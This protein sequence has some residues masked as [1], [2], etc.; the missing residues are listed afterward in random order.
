MLPPFEAPSG[1]RVVYTDVDGTMLGRAGA[2]VRDPSGALTLE[3]AEALTQTLDAGID[4]VPCSGRAL[5][6]LVGDARILGLASVIGEMGSVIAYEHG[7]EVVRNLG[8]YP[9]GDVL[10]VVY[11]KECGAVGL[12]LERYRLEHHTPWSAWREYTHLFRGLVE[13]DEA[14]QALALAGFG[15]CEIQDNGRLHGAYVGLPAGSA[16]AYHLVPRGT[17]KASAVLLDRTRRGLMPEECVAIGDAMADLGVARQ[18]A[19]LVLVRDALER[20]EAL[21][22][23]ATAAPN[24]FSTERPGNLGW[25]EV[26]SALARAR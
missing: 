15:W 26:V 23:A 5:R 9:G 20:D 8:E 7:A 21:A 14:N 22:A 10:P 13:V 3:P 24:A 2:F 25:A 11:M 17:S 18:V 19:A 12:L 4:V 1:V 16:H 6:G